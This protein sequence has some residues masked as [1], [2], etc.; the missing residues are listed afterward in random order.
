MSRASVVGEVFGRVA[1]AM[2]GLVALVGIAA[3]SAQS[4]DTSGST[5]ARSS[6]ERPTVAAVEADDALR[7]VIQS[8]EAGI[9]HILVS[10]TDQ[11]LPLACDDGSSVDAITGI[12]VGKGCR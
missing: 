8:A 5:S 10:A 7:L 3:C 11:T 2:A 1:L 12:L 6:G 9:P 4:P